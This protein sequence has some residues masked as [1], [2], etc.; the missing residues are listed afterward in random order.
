VIG[1]FEGGSIGTG[2]ML[3][4]GVHFTLTGTALVPAR[5]TRFNTVQ[6]NSG[7]AWGNRY[8]MGGIVPYGNDPANPPHLE[9]RFTKWYTLASGPNHFRDYWSQGAA[10]MRD[11]EFYCGNLGSYHPVVAFTNCLFWG[12]PMQ[13]DNNSAGGAPVTMQNCLLRNCVIW[14]GRYTWQTPVNWTIRDTAFEGVSYTFVDGFSGNTNYTFFDHNAYITGQPTLTPV[15]TSNVTVSSFGWQTGPLGFCYLA[16]NSPLVN[17]GSVSADVVGLFHY[18]VT[19]NL[20]SGLEIKETNSVVDLSYHYVAVDANG[21]PIDSDGDG[22][23]DYLEDAN[24]NGRVDSGETDWQNAADLGLRV[25]ITR[26]RPGGT[27]P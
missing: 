1:W 16:T 26:P 17:T 24:G 15:G 4:N 9:A 8:W 5:V 10:Q 6:E 3:G 14:L 27:L 19:T 11:C 18:T 12:D 20:I 13:F 22:I 2:V 25:R 23:A 7:G 21:N